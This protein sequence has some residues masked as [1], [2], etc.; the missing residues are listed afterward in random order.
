MVYITLVLRHE[1][2]GHTHTLVHA[3]SISTRKS[4]LKS[5]MRITYSANAH[6]GDGDTLVLA[7]QLGQCSHHLAC[8]CAA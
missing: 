4:K 3:I 8:T 2:T 5:E 6:R 1:D 7:S